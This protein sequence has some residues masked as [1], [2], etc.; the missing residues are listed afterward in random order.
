MA[1]LSNMPELVLMRMADYLRPEDTARLASTCRRLHSILPAFLV[2]KGKEFHADG[3][4]Y[5]ESVKNGAPPE[6]Y[7]DG[8]PL[9]S[10]VK[11]LNMSVVWKDQGWGNM[12][13]ELFVRLMRPATK[14]TLKG[15][16]LQGKK[17]DPV[18]VAE[19]RKVFGIAKHE[20]EESK[21]EIRNDSILKLA[22][23]G[24]FY[25]FMRN[26]GGGG[27]HK[28]YVKKFKAVA[29]LTQRGHSSQTY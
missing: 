19:K 12:K 2:M 25:R 3:P 4:S 10:T 17:G 18:M 16:S 13:G 22:E 1:S 29:T 8:P 28:L 14:Q 7:F 11:K 24:D 6:L 5:E 23:P 27:N 15:D 20:E 21:V 26:V 9:T